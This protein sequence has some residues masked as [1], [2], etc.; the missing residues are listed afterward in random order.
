[1]P[2]RLL[3]ARPPPPLL[4]HLL[5]LSTM[6][7]RHVMRLHLERDDDRL[8]IRLNEPHRSSTDTHAMQTRIGAPATTTS[9]SFAAMPTLACHRTMAVIRWEFHAMMSTITTTVLSRLGRPL[10][11]LL[12]R[13]VVV[14]ASA[15]ARPPT[16][17]L[18]VAIATTHA[19]CARRSPSSAATA[20]DSPPRLPWL[21]PM[22]ATAPLVRSKRPTSALAQ[23]QTQLAALGTQLCKR[24]EHQRRRLPPRLMMLLTLSRAFFFS[25][26]HLHSSKS[27]PYC[28]L[29]IFGMLGLKLLIY[30]M[31]TR[32]R[33][34]CESR[35]RVSFQWIAE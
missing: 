3:Y 10:R 19:T 23:T 34:V 18:I 31:R 24:T 9:T 11:L 4:L 7:R 22:V 15:W 16:I 8:A 35:S 20:V 29:T 21:H 32:M 1:M 17:D 27:P 26:T 5:H 30:S 12:Q 6:S 25:S 13:Q 2:R 14:V 33:S 28:I